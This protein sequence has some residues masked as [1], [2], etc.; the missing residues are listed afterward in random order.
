MIAGSVFW[1][2]PGPSRYRRSHTRHLLEGRSLVIVLPT[3]VDARGL[4]VEVAHSA[5]DAGFSF[6]SYAVTGLFAGDN[7]VGDA[8]CAV[9]GIE[10]SGAAGPTNAAAL[11]SAERLRGVVLWFSDSE[12]LTDDQRE[13]WFRFLSDFGHAARNEQVEER[14]R[15]VMDLNHHLPELDDLFFIRCWW[16][17]VLGH[18]DQLCA[19]D[20]V[21]QD[22]DIDAF[23][24]G[25]V[26]HVAAYD[27]DLLAWLLSHEFE[28]AA[29]LG[30][31]LRLYA[32]ESGLTQ[33]ADL[34]KEALAVARA[35]TP[36]IEP[37]DNLRELWRAGGVQAMVRE[38]IRIHP[39]VL[40]LVEGDAAAE[41]ML[42]EAQVRSLLPSIDR[43]RVRV[44]QYLDRRFGASWITWSPNGHTSGLD[45]EIG[46]LKFL[47]DTAPPLSRESA[48]KR[49]FV[50]RL[51]QARND[52]A[53]LR[54]VNRRAVSALASLAVEFE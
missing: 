39:A 37:P 23:L 11:A 30:Q 18:A 25:A 8:L 51:H 42:W 14:P 49:E 45:F 15:V 19:F 32:R 22:L 24:E 41:R 44:S 13:R 27:L 2:L 35:A 36:G 52:L 26:I 46:D 16:W 1:E 38:G 48:A 20:L 31:T 5:R 33:V 4:Q 3:D 43:Y 7:E 47:W 17:A 6:E 21:S 53:H 10:K 29:S 40:A 54:P 28:D 12:L 9:L 34:G 50:V